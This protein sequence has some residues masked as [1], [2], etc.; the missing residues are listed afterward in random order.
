MQAFIVLGLIPGTNIQIGF[1]LI[2]LI[3]L[4]VIIFLLTKYLSH[5]RQIKQIVSSLTQRQPLPARAF[6]SRLQ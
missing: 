3:A 2:A 1:A 4:I 5:Y 6:H